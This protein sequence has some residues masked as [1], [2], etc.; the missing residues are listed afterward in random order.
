MQMSQPFGMSAKRAQLK[1]DVLNYTPCHT[2][3]S[4]VSHPIDALVFAGHFFCSL[5]LQ[6]T[7]L[8]GA[9][10]RD[11]REGPKNQRGIGNLS[12]LRGSQIL[13]PGHL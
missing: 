3:Q 13:S 12:G 4:A 9:G 8:K 2:K 1:W 11:A 5:S 6:G 10:S 7:T